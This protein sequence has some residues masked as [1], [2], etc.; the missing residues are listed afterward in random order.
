M[1]QNKL[2]AR[3]S[4]VASGLLLITSAPHA[5]GWGITWADNFTGVNN[6]PYS[7]NWSYDT[8]AG[9]WG[10]QELETYVTSWA[11]AH[12]ISDG[13]GTDNQALQIEAQTDSSEIG[14]AHV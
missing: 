8:G 13:T 14:R 4:L 9:G 2:F 12:V 6:E 10:N 7:G 3:V 1:K 5:L 11:N